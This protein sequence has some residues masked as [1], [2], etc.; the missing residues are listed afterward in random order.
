MLTS[1]T[2]DCSCNAV[3]SY[4]KTRCLEN[5]MLISV[6]TRNRTG[7]LV[8]TSF[9]LPLMCV[10]VHIHT[11][12]HTVSPP[13][14]PPWADLASTKQAPRLC[15]GPHIKLREHSLSLKWGP[16]GFHA[17][18]VSVHGI[19]LQTRARRKNRTRQCPSPTSQLPSLLCSYNDIHI[20][21]SFSFCLKY[22]KLCWRNETSNT[23]HT[24][25]N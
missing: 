4:L 6:R 17:R 15:Q 12:A 19:S 16:S 5:T 25:A 9:S 24:T 14:A 3:T 11:H 13:R 21:F 23:S 2:T 7:S 1:V 8:T 18:L 10:H 20:L 22:N